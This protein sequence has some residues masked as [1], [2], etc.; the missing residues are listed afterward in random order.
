M[1][2]I[3]WVDLN[4]TELEM[5][6]ETGKQ[7]PLSEQACDKLKALL[8]TLVYLMN[9]LRNN[10]TT[11]RKLRRMLFGAATEKTSNVLNTDAETSGGKATDPA[12]PAGQSP[13]PDKG[14]QNQDSEK[15]RKGHG[16]KR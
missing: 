1:P 15:K 5:L 16:R 10:Q 3:E 2:T 4:V 9:L 11:I 13:A 12:T 7:A 6:L 14:A 8:R